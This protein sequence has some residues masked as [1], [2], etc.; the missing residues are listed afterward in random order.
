[1][2]ISLVL[3]LSL[4][5]AW[6]A[7]GGVPT[8]APSG[9]TV[10]A[11]PV[12]ADAVAAA[13][14]ACSPASTNM[15]HTLQARHNDRILQNDS[16]QCPH[17]YSVTPFRL[18]G[19]SGSVPPIHT[20]VLTCAYIHMHTYLVQ[21]PYTHRAERWNV[22]TIGASQ[23]TTERVHRYGLAPSVVHHNPRGALTQSRRQ[24]QRRRWQRGRSRPWSQ[25]C[26]WYTNGAHVR[27][28]PHLWNITKMVNRI[29]RIVHNLDT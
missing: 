12:S 3:P 2:S 6:P 15:A 22:A 13:N 19:L 24:M 29:D 11:P 20:Y 18:W 9:P 8:Q 1:M 28:A 26:L 10:V 14:V 25:S 7:A 27:D 21:P 4:S 16:S 23:Q 17:I 5:L